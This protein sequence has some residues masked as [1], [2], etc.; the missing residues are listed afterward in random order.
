MLA[1]PGVFRGLLDAR[2]SQVTTEMLLRAAHAIAAVVTDEELHPSFI[3]PSVFHPDVPGAVASGH[4]RHGRLRP[5]WGART[6]R[7]SQAVPGGS[8]DAYFDGVRSTVRSTPR[9]RG[10]S[11]AACD[12]GFSAISANDHLVFQRPW[13]DGI[14]TLASV[15]ERSRVLTLATTAP[16]PDRA[17]SLL[18]L[19]T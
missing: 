12:S 1:F 15:V 10:T 7:R 8:A 6:A 3:I 9:L 17:Q 4:P 5:A 11:S 13:L 2:A 18:D 16:P 19:L 14:V